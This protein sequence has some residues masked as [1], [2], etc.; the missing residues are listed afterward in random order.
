M[1]LICNSYKQTLKWHEHNEYDSEQWAM[2]YDDIVTSSLWIDSSFVSVLN[3]CVRWYDETI[4]VFTLLD[5]SC[6]SYNWWSRGCIKEQLVTRINIMKLHN[7]C[8]VSLIWHIN[9]SSHCLI[10]SSCSV[11]SL[12]MFILCLTSVSRCWS[13]HVIILAYINCIN[14][15]QP[16]SSL[17]ESRLRSSTTGR[18][19][20]Q[21]SD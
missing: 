15:S 1:M 21:V 19:S 11:L 17:A 18:S 10:S 20:G 6:S 7:I 2:K 13:S 4:L 16:Q 5:N 8:C 9:S 14:L 3:T 12:E